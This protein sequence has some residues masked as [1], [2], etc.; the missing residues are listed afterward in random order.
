M[1]V[2]YAV[3]IVLS[4]LTIHLWNNDRFKPSCCNHL[5]NDLGSDQ[6]LVQSWKS[7]QP[8]TLSLS[9]INLIRQTTEKQ[10][11]ALIFSANCYSK[12]FFSFEFL[13]ES[14][15]DWKCNPTFQKKKQLTVSCTFHG[16]K[17]KLLLLGTN[18]SSIK[19]CYV[20]P[21]VPHWSCCTWD[22]AIKISIRFLCCFM[23]FLNISQHRRL[24]PFIS[25]YFY[26]HLIKVNIKISDFLE[27]NLTVCH[28]CQILS[29]LKIS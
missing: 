17:F 3:L 4:N 5:I 11:K 29:E 2:L 20:T 14:K 6:I 16:W 15:C 28:I 21:H 1:Y 23:Y 10:E 27:L 18:I 13:F 12:F 24:F 8:S 9:T 22:E 19:N 7:K 26:F 25:F